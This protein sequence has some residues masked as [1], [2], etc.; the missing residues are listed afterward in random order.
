MKTKI[1][2]ALIAV[3]AL[4]LSLVGLAVAQAVQYQNNA[5]APQDGSAP[6]S[7]FWGWIGSC[8]GWRDTQTNYYGEPVGPQN[9]SSDQAASNQGGYY[10]GYGPCWAR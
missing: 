10:Y 7:G 9:P 3:S 4:A 8:F 5:T 1:I 2:V 6:N